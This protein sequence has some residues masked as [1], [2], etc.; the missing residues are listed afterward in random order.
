MTTNHDPG[1]GLA[2]LATRD[3]ANALGAKCDACNGSGRGG[4]G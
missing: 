2:M 4:H 1:R 3:L